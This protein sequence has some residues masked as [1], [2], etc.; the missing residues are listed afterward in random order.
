[1][2]LGA[3]LA[4]LFIGPLSDRY[5]RRK[6]ILAA[7]VV[8][9]AGSI[10]SGIASG[11]TTL[12]VSRVLL[13]FGVG[14]AS[15]LIPT[16]LSEVSPADKRGSLTGLFQFMVM[17]GILLAFVSN[18]A[19]S[20]PQ[21]GWRWMLGLAALPSLVLFLGAL[22]L[23]ESPRFLVKTG[24]TSEARRVLLD[25]YK[26]DP[27][28]VDSQ[29]TE[30]K[31]QAQMPNGGWNEL[32]GSMARPALFAAIG[33]AVFQQIMGCNTVLYYAPT[34]F[35]VV[36]FGVSAALIAHIGI[37]I[38]NVIVTAIGIKLMDFI[39][40]KKMLIYGALGMGLSLF[41]MSFSMHFS[42]RSQSA[43]WICALA[44]TIYIAFSPQHGDR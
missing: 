38:F 24:R 40:R 44:L 32:F 41:I 8:F 7:A 20:G 30:I 16:Y 22:I 28:V 10:G 6:L 35:T 12:V 33:L 4:S 23:P 1:M 31:R 27:A 37:G 34:I 25:M 3:V 5:G 17:T 21:S 36:G 13:G 11:F 39:D 2:L 9:F 43:A 42:G 15:S 19:L 26:G 18:Y 29:L 14:I